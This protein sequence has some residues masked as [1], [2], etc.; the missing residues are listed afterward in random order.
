MRKLLLILIITFFTSVTSYSQITILEKQEPYRVTNEYGDMIVY[1]LT[2][3]L[4][5]FDSLKFCNYAK[6][7]Y[8][9]FNMFTMYSYSE[10]IKS[11]HLA[12]SGLGYETKGSNDYF[13]LDFYYLDK[14]LIVTND[15]HN[16]FNR[17]TDE[18]VIK[19]KQRL[20]QLQAK[21]IKELQLL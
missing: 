4:D 5:H 14:K 17:F 21:I 20:N 19:Y 3:V 10:I 16:F 1:H 6:R 8:D 11:K 18:Q 15:W 9:S 13:S 7:L 12:V 2:I